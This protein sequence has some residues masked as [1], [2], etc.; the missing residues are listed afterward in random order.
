MAGTVPTHLA[1]SAQGLPIPASGHTS[2]LAEA[3][4]GD[5][6]PGAV[7]LCLPSSWFCPGKWSQQLEHS[8]QEATGTKGAGVPP[9][10]AGG[11]GPTLSDPEQEVAATALAEVPGFSC[12]PGWCLQEG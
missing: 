8:C 11:S 7:A 6:G 3:G 1:A 10:L 12:R 9:R 2:F 4:Q 5:R